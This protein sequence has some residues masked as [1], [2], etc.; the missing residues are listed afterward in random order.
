MRKKY[1]TYIITNHSNSVLYT[2]VTNNLLRRIWEH[3]TGTIKSSFSS[4]YKLYKLVW[5][6]EF[7][8]INDSLN[9]EKMIK[10]WK[11][12]KKI[13]LIKDQNSGFEDLAKNIF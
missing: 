4:K 5:F 1:Y 7:S 6:Q 11:R 3:K 12:E 9:A 8:Y 2:G 13:D 10:G